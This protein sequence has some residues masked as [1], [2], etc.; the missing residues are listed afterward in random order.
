MRRESLTVIFRNSADGRRLLF[1][2]LLLALSFL[3]SIIMSSLRFPGSPTAPWSP[4]SGLSVLAALSARRKHWLVLLWVMI[5]TAAAYMI[6]GTE[7]WVSLCFGL[8]GAAETLVVLAIM[9]GHHSVEWSSRSGWVVRFVSA[10]VLGGMIGGAV[11][12]GALALDHMAFLPHFLSVSASHISAIILIGG[13]GIV[14]FNTFRVR[15][16]GELLVQLAVLA[17]TLLAA[18]YPGQDQP[19]AFLLFPVLAWAA[20]RFGVAVVLIEVTCVSI[21]SM[22]LGAFGGG[23]FAHAAAGAPVLFM[24]LNQLFTLSLSVS[25]LLL[26]TLQ[27]DHNSMLHHLRAREK[28]LQGSL[29]ST[30]GGFLLLEREDGGRFTMVEENPAFERLM[31]DWTL[32]VH[33]DGSRSI[34]PEIAALPGVAHA[35]EKE[36]QGGLLWND[37][38]L[39]MH[40]AP[41]GDDRSALLIQTVDVTEERRTEEAMAQA[42][43]HEREL[44]RGMRKLNLQKDEFIASVSHE[45][46]TPVTS[47]LGY[48]EELELPDLSEEDQELLEVVT[49]NARRLAE[50]IDDLLTLSITSEAAPY[51]P[52]DVDVTQTVQQAVSDL[53]R[54]AIEKGVT[55]SAIACEPLVVPAEP[56][57][58][59]RAI[60][61]LIS[62]SVKFSRPG[63]SVTVSVSESDSEAIIEIV[64]TGPGIDPGEIG[65]VFGRF[66]RVVGTG[67]DYKEGTGLGLPMVSE[68]M[69]RMG[70][71]VWLD[72]DGKNGVTATVRLPK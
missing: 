26:A 69:E 12:A 72:S 10:A 5:L 1:I 32:Q 60:S 43:A 49:R 11:K 58:L 19:F 27:D 50:L 51:V 59:H 38:Q 45:L 47:I 36:W 6:T 62:N 56:L 42:L 21:A 13:F 71:S 57:W 41:V 54:A 48:A 35:S 22:V 53:S 66:Y 55:L 63:D 39:M 29:I 70:G 16:V 68:L 23:S 44:T 4:T 14:P 34:A 40:V 67:S 64:D 25:M 61:N 9:R 20:L 31:P 65:K 52:V 2:V 3:L 28:L 30:N 33:Q 8:A 15:W 37:R 7:W 18:F 17:L 24:G 46:R